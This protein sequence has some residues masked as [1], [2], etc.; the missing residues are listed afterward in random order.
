MSTWFKGYIYTDEIFSQTWRF[1]ETYKLSGVP[2]IT[3]YCECNEIENIKMWKILYYEPGGV[4][5]YR[6]HDPCCN[7]LI[8]V[9]ELFLANKETI[10][11]YDIEKDFYT[12]I[13]KLNSIGINVIDQI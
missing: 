7:L 1:E 13:K 10:K 11:I 9:H 5:V 8:I 3:S 6:A 2:A 4:G 12:I